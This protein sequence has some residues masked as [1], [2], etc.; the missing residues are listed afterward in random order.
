MSVAKEIIS[1]VGEVVQS[2]EN[3]D[4]YEGSNFMR[5]SRGK[6]TLSN[7]RPNIF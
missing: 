4:E 5:V 7:G 6:A 3:S 2:K 1:A